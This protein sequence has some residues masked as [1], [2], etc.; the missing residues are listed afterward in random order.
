MGLTSRSV[1][2]MAYLYSI[3]Q[4]NGKIKVTQNRIAEQCDM[5]IKTV[6]KHINILRDFGYITRID[7]DIKEHSM[8]VFGTD[9]Y[10]LKT[11]PESGFFAVPRSVFRQEIEPKLFVMYLLHCQAEDVNSGIHWNS[12]N[13]LLKRASKIF[14]EKRSVIIALVKKLAEMKLIVKYRQRVRNFRGKTTN[15]DNMY[16]TIKHVKGKI[17]KK[18]NVLSLPQ[19]EN[20]SYTILNSNN[21]TIY[22]NNTTEIEVCQ[23]DYDIFLKKI[24]ERKRSLEAAAERRR[25][26][27]R[28]SCENQLFLPSFG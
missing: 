15:I 14:S 19:S 8:K 26:C 28:F 1:K 17:H 2:V 9:T 23:E 18:R 21:S 11:L 20:I 25:K 22:I 6:R 16:G 3:P 24:F 5:D 4:K 12:Y 13:D 7:K 27:K 10:T